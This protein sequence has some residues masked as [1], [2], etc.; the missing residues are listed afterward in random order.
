MF[1]KPYALR[2]GELGDSERDRDGGDLS[3]AR[4]D[5]TPRLEEADSD[6]DGRTPPIDCGIYLESGARVWVVLIAES[7]G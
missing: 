4:V 1:G 2:S 6:L 7:G 3:A 5:G